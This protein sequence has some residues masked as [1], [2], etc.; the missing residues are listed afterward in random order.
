MI[1]KFNLLDENDNLHKAFLRN[2][3]E[4]NMSMKQ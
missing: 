3:K 2:D 1:F 4:D